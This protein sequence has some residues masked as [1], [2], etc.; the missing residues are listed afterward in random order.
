MS[1][2][3]QTNMNYKRLNPYVHTSN[4]ICVQKFYKTLIYPLLTPKGNMCD[5]MYIIYMLHNLKKAS[6][7]F[8]A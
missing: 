7:F 1:H 4:E 3:I 2:E 6:H 8:D 5:N